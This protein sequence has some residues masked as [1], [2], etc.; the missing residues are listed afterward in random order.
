[1]AEDKDSS[2]KKPASKNVLWKLFVS[3]P[4]NQDEMNETIGLLKVR[5]M[6]FLEKLTSIKRSEQQNFL[7]VQTSKA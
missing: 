7:S 6:G 4:K 2:N 1:M 3:V 5:T